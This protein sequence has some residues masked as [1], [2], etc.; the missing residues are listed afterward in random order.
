MWAGD[1]SSC[2]LQRLPQDVTFL[3]DRLTRSV[4]LGGLQIDRLVADRAILFWL[5]GTCHRAPPGAASV[6]LQRA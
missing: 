4:C 1:G 2:I 3:V 5:G 6:H